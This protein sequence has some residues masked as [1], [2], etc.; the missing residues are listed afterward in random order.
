MKKRVFAVT[1]VLGLMLALA[2]CGKKE[3]PKKKATDLCTLGQYKGVEVEKMVIE[4]SD[5]DVIKNIYTALKK[6]AT[7][8]S[9]HR[10]VELYDIANIDFKGYLGDEAFQGGEGEDYDLLIG[11]GS[12]IP[13]F[14]EAIIGAEV[15]TT[16]K[17]S[18]K[19]PD[20]YG[21]TDLAGKDATFVIT[22]NEIKSFPEFTDEFIAEN[23][24][25]KTLAE[26]KASVRTTLENNAASNIEN[27][28][29]SDVMDKVIE[30]CT[31]DDSLNEDI[32]KYSEDLKNLYTQYA[33]SNGIDLE[34]FLYYM[35]G[36]SLSYFEETL[37]E[38]SEYNVKVERILN[39]VAEVENIT[40]SEEEYNKEI[41]TLIAESSYET[42][43][44]VEE[45]YTKEAIENS[46]KSKKAEDVIF[47]SAVAK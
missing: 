41:E 9:G 6:H 12:F 33:A 21:S 37:P 22:V 15:G 25:Y 44:A 35:Y 14:E 27:K 24:S 31:F 20:D 23:T 16:F 28:F 40:V 29:K 42:K 17:I 2:A 19:F 26:Y 38:I 5:D 3:E 45:A 30:G 4:V 46:I 1:L 47:N 43:E 32:K 7:V 11:S 18:V 13:G 10:R 36:V 39:A 8:V 34:T